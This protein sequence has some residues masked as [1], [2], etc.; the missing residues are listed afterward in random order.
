MRLNQPAINP[1]HQ[2]LRVRSHFRMRRVVDPRGLE[3]VVAYPGRHLALDSAGDFSGRHTSTFAPRQPQS[4]ALGNLDLPHTGGLTRFDDLLRIETLAWH[5]DYHALRLGLGSQ[6][7]G[8]ALRR[9]RVVKRQILVGTER[10]RVIHRCADTSLLACPLGR[11]DFTSTECLRVGLLDFLM[12]LAASSCSF[13]A[14]ISEHEGVATSN[15]PWLPA[16][17]R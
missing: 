13:A 12:I 4:R 1:P 7:F 11:H 17:A 16:F 14:M 8:H 15:V 9:G 6:L 2:R 10:R 3:W 5:M